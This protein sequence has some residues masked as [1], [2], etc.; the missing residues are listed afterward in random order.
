MN[1]SAQHLQAWSDPTNWS[2]R[3]IFGLYFNK[4]D[5]RV[6]VPKANPAFGWTLNLARPAGAAVFLCAL[7]LPTAALAAVAL[8]VGLS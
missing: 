3:G 8:A 5:A 7:L 2:H 4:Q 1:T 6:L